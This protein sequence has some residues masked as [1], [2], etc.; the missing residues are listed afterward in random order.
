MFSYLLIYHSTKGTTSWPF[1]VS[2]WFSFSARQW[3]SFMELY[4]SHLSTP[5]ETRVQS[6]LKVDFPDFI[7]SMRSMTRPLQTHI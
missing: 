2:V 3:A 6:L 4:F 5:S 7:F 1:L